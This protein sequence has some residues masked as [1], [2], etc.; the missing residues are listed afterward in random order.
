MSGVDIVK[1][2]RLVSMEPGTSGSSNSNADS[3]NV[4]DLEEEI[5]FSSPSGPAGTNFPYIA[6]SFPTAEHQL[7]HDGLYKFPTWSVY[8]PELT[9]CL[10]A[11]V[12][13]QSDSSYR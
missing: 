5:E 13:I 10:I 9:K 11:T 6:Q 4:E 2:L 12:H 7:V 1:L 8:T 3:D